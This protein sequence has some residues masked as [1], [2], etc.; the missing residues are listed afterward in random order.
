M[1]HY[2][3]IATLENATIEEDALRM[4]ARAAEGSVRDGLSLL[5]QAIAYGEGVVKGADVAGMLGLSDRSR[6][7]DLFDAV[8]AGDAPR[9][10]GELATQYEAG[11]DPQTILTDLADF[12]HWVTR[13][14]LVRDMALMDGARTESE[15]T[16]GLEFAEKLSIPAVSR[17]W[18]MLLKGIQETAIA[19]QP[20]QAAEMVLI[21]LAHAMDLPP[22]DELLRLARSATVTAI[23]RPATKPAAPADAGSRMAAAGNLA[24]AIA[25]EISTTTTASPQAP[26]ATLNSFAELLALVVERRDVKLKGELERYVRPIS[27][28]EGRFEFALEPSAPP[29]LPNELTRKLEAWTGK[30][31]IISIAREGGAPPMQQQRKSAREIALAEARNLPLVQAVLKAFPGAEVFDVREPTL[32]VIPNADLTMEDHDEESH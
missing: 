21:R 1:Q 25:R 22:H 5:D 18:Q 23:E 26:G 24:P 8:M 27:I 29:G 12:I 28:G 13:L 20:M 15:K 19:A 2:G 31:Y 7:I 3:R 6:V 17:A 14:R 32:P 10:L 4:I 30:R 16:R 11:A 9:A